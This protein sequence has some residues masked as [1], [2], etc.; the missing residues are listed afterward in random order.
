[1]NNAAKKQMA[2]IEYTVERRGSAT[3]KAIEVP[4]DKVER[5][6]DKLVETKD[7]FNFVTMLESRP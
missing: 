4:V 2:R 7:A 6:I 1:M 3:R 5:T